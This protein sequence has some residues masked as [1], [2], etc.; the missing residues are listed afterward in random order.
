VYYFARKLPATPDYVN[1]GAF[2]TGEVA[3]VMANLKFLH[4]P[5]QVVDYQLANV[6][7]TYWINFITNGNP[8]GKGLPVWPAFNTQTY[9]AIVFNNGA[10]KQE[11]PDKDELQFMANKASK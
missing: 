10:V 1:Y 6:M 4:R 3:N 2:H 11:L 9:P 5:W 8:N 7:S